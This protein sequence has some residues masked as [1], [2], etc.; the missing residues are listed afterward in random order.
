MAAGKRAFPFQRGKQRSHARSKVVTFRLH[1]LCFG[2]KRLHN[3]FSFLSPQPCV[4]GDFFCVCVIVAVA[5]RQHEKQSRSGSKQE[6][7]GA[8]PPRAPR[9]QALRRATRLVSDPMLPTHTP[10]SF[11]HREREREKER[12]THTHT[13]THIHT[14]THKHTHTHTHTHK[15]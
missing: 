15:H 1:R 3:L 13:H 4:R 11:P 2:A 6:R 5:E 10:S 7:R 8:Q 14:Q 12:D 9:F